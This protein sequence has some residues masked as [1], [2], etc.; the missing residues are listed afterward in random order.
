MLLLSRPPILATTTATRLSVLPRSISCLHLHPRLGWASTSA[1][2][3]TTISS[4][5]SSFNEETSERVLGLWFPGFKLDETD[6]PAD[7]NPILQMWFR[8]SDEFDGKCG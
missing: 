4:R 7:P 3:V 5:M 1:R 2:S 8:R 6:Y